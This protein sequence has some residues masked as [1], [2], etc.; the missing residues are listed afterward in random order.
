MDLQTNTALVIALLMQLAGLSYVVWRDPYIRSEH[1]Q[2]LLASIVFTL[3]LILQ[4][5]L[6]ALLVYRQEGV[7]LVT[8]NSVIGYVLRPFILVLFIQ[9]VKEDWRPWILV[10]L[11]IAIN[12]LA[13]ATH[14]VFWFDETLHFKRGPLGYTTHII[15]FILLFWLIYKTKERYKELKGYGIVLPIAIVT[16]ILAAT[17]A[18]TMLEDGPITSYLTISIVTCCVFYYIW[19]HQ[20][21]VLE[22]EEALRAEQRIRIMVSQIQPHFLFNTLTTIQALCRIDPEKASDTVGKF[23]QYLRQNID[24]LNQPDLILFETE[25]EHTKIYAEIEMVRFPK[26]KV[27]YDIEDLHFGVP[28]LTLQP[29]VENAIRHGVRVRQ[30]G[31]ILISTRQEETCHVIRIRD[32]GKG[33]DVEAAMNADASHIGLRNVKERVKTMCGGSMKIQSVIGEGT[34]IIVS[35][36]FRKD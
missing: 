31:R 22:H 33:F 29:L 14:W 23:S 10:G 11:N 6:G 18:D 1:R 27:E 36:P 30:D 13:F 32:N 19:L 16:V 5:C 35:I 9:I 26:I 12:S 17:L 4:N 15:G 2:Y 24:S 7:F 25:L 8:L 3:M 20:Q 28:A 21:Y 34:E